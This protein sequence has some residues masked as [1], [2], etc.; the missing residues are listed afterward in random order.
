MNIPQIARRARTL[1]LGAGSAFLA[2]SL[3]NGAHA[4][5]GSAGGDTALVR[6]V[7]RAKVSLQRAL[8]VA[9]ARGRPISAKYEIEDGK[10]QLSVYTAKAGRFWEVIVNHQTGHI[11]KAEE[12]KEGDD[13]TAAKAQQ[14]AMAKAK[15]SL[16]AAV[17]RA[18]KATPGSRAVSVT[19]ALEGGKAVASISLATAGMTKTVSEP[20]D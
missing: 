9:S 4:Q 19:P 6:Q 17:S 5:E 14:E 13:L 16:S 2:T 11:A 10:L 1:I 3:P 15:R 8:S 18:L 12:I 20:L 7:R